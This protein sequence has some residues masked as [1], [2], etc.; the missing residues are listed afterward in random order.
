MLA[1]LTPHAGGLTA[2]AAS[3]VAS[4]S[5]A[6]VLGEGIYAGFGFSLRF[7]APCPPANPGP[8]QNCCDGVAWAGGSSRQAV[9]I[10]GKEKAAKMT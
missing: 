3:V 6:A 8:S 5:C 2:A 9:G 10:A 4:P 7:Q 1:L